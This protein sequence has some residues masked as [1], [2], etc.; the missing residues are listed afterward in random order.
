MKTKTFDCVE[1]KRECQRKLRAEYEARKK[2]FA[3]FLDFISRNAEESE[4]WKKVQAMAAGA[5]PKNSPDAPP[6][7]M[8]S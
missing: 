3:S 4:L 1:M 7:S 6:I 2:E 5:R 8:I